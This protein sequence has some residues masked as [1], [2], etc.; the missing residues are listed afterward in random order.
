MLKINKG[1]EY[2]L[3]IQKYLTLN[4]S[5]YQSYLWD[6]VPFKYIIKFVFDDLTKYDMETINENDIIKTVD[7]GCDILMV[8]KDNDDDVIIVQCKNYKDKKVCID[9]LSGFFYL[10]ALSHVPLKGLIISN[11]DISN[12]IKNKLNLIDKVKFLN[13]PYIEEIK[14]IEEEIIISRD[15]QLEAVKE[16]ENINKGILQLFCGMGKTHTSILIAK[17]FKNIIILSPLRSYASQLLNV[18]ENSLKNY[19]SNLISSDGNRD[20]KTILNNKKENN[21]YSVTFYSADIILELIDNLDNII[22]IVDEF[23]NLS[24]SNVTNSNNTI[25]KIIMS[26]KITKKLF[27][28]ATPKVYE[29]IKEDEVIEHSVDNYKNI[30]GEIFY[31]YDF[32][33]AIENKYIN[34]YRLIIPN[35]ENEKNKYNF[36]YSNMLYHGYKKCLIYCQNIEEAKIFE[37][38]IFTINKIKYNFKIFLNLITYKTPL[39]KRN[40]ILNE[41]IKDEY[42][43]SFI[44]SVHTLDECIDIPKCDSVYITYNVK[45]P[46]NIMQRISRCLRVYQNKI[47]SGIFIW[48][49]KYNDLVKINDIVKNYDSN[50]IN[51]IY[52]KNNEGQNNKLLKIKND[53]KK[54]VIENVVKNDV[55]DNDIVVELN[56]INNVVENDI[57]NNIIVENDVVELNE[58]NS[59]VFKN[60]VINNIAKNDAI[61]NNN[62]IHLNFIKYYVNGN[63]VI[64]NNNIIDLK[65][66][67]IKHDF[68]NIDDLQKNVI[69]KVSR[70]KNNNVNN[71][72]IKNNI[73]CIDAINK[74]IC[75]KCGR[76][77]K[78]KYHLDCHNNKKVPCIKIDKQ[79]EI[80]TIKEEL[81]RFK[82]ENLKL[83]NINKSNLNNLVNKLNFN[84]SV[85]INN[86]VTIVNHGS[87]DYIK[88]DIEMFMLN[89][90][91]LSKFNYISTIINHI[92]CNDNYPEYQNI[93]ISDM[94][95]NDIYVY[96]N[97]K[98]ILKNKN[99]TVENLIEHMIN[100][101]FFI[102]EKNSFGEEF[103]NYIAEINE[104]TPNTNSYLL[105]NK[106][107]VIK[108]TELVLYNNKDKIKA[109]KKIKKIQKL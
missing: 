42:K 62:N 88:L 97:E 99:E 26:N 5:N 9:D 87:E 25:N 75:Q 15:Y 108:N 95:R 74:Y 52:I 31:S 84:N 79:I 6:D 45:N 83:K 13:I 81:E 8:N 18:F 16:F 55:V 107:N 43:L 57:I 11:T 105:K 7:I 82:F 63:N 80:I 23:H 101:L 65:K 103:K 68:N 21:I 39:K 70:K 66:N 14:I 2:E 50:L 44:I 28:S 73:K 34:D 4:Y 20:I 32:K 3:Q 96:I 10:I 61:N 90:K 109:I 86:N 58:V 59:I 56:I 47:K 64:K 85:I 12:R 89:N 48:C 77:F 37:K 30:F 29:S 35:D 91:N 1:S 54:N 71:K 93:Y 67:E 38:E 69:T 51:K 94:T 106:K 46:I 98:W 102:L 72:L 76:D 22:L 27:M 78:R 41:F 40:K 53:L 92:Y 60:N 49:D 24:Y 100:I 19:S 36:I 33:K 104:I 17:E